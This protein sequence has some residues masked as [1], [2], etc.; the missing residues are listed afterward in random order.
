MNFFAYILRRAARHWQILLTLILGVLLSTALLASS[1]VLINTVVE[2]GLRRNLLAAPPLEGN[3]RLRAYSNR[4]QAE[5]EALSQQVTQIINQRLG[6]HVSAIVPSVQTRAFFPWLRAQPLPEQ[7][8]SLLFYGQGETDIA[9]R[10][11]F[12]AG[13]WPQEPLVDER[14]LAVVIGADMATAYQLEVGDRLPLSEKQSAAQPDL[15]LAVVGIATPLEPLDRYWFGEFNPL[16]ERVDERQQ[17]VYTAVMPA[18]DFFRSNTTFFVNAPLDMYWQVLLAPETIG[19]QDIPALRSQLGR[20][21][22]DL[23]LLSP[24]ITVNTGL[25]KMLANFAAQAATVRAPL[26]FLTAEVVLLILYYV[27]MVSA[28]A[29]RQ[30]ERE[31]AVLQS[32]GASGGQIFRIQ[33]GE[34]LIISLVAL[35]A[36]PGLGLA[37]VRGLVVAGPLADV[38][39]PGWAL[40][41]PQVA[42]LTAVV[43][44]LAALAGLLLP[45]RAAIKRSIIAYQ[46]A[47][48]R[49]T[50]VP[51]WQRYYL[52]V[53][54]LALGLALLLR[55][56]FYGSIVGGSGARPQVD[57]LLLLSPIALLVG[58]GAILLRI[59]PLVLRLLAAVAS[60]GRGLPAALALWQTARNPSHVARLVLLLTLA[61]SLGILSTGINATLDASEAERARYETGGEVRLASRRFVPL[62]QVGTL[63]G[64]ADLTSVWR[65]QGS[66][67]IGRDYLRF[68][69]LAIEPYSFAHVTRY[70]EDFSE[71]GMGELLGDLVVDD[72]RSQPLILLPGKP[73]EFGLWLW[74]A[75]TQ[76]QSGPVLSGDS[77]LDRVGLEVKLQTVQ[78]ELLNLELT[79]TETGGY[80]A[81]GWRYFRADLPPL[82]DFNYPVGVHSIWL[83][84]LARTA[85][86]NRNTATS[87][88]LAV[89]TLTVVDKVTG[90]TA[91][92]NDM[93][94]LTEIWYL[95]MLGAEKG[96]NTISFNYAIFHTGKASQWLFLN[97]NALQQ[98]ALKLV[99]PTLKPAP[100]P[101]LAHAKFLQSVQGQVGDELT[102]V[103][104][105]QPM[106][107]RVVGVVNYFPTMYAEQTAGYLIMNRDALLNALNDSASQSVNVN[108]VL[109]MVEGDVDQ[110][111]VASTALTA[112]TSINQAWSV[113]AIRKAIKADPMALGLRSVTF[114]GYVLTTMLS[115]VGFG[116]YFY[117][118]ARQRENMYGVLRSIGMSPRQLYGALALEQVVLI[119]AGL[120]I[121][122]VLGVALNQITLPGLPI[123]FSDRSPTPPF[124]ALND[125]LAVARIYL[126]LAFAFLITLGLAT[127]LLWRTRLHRVLRVGEE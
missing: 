113:D 122:T 11:R 47:A 77:D 32:R 94:T 70:R 37:L 91:V 115:L 110:V 46:Q 81:D 69:I 44:V 66:T 30:V 93:E 98:V 16:R 109:L 89:D 13:G 75:E 9:T 43:G 108:E 45:V 1:P 12:E 25:D 65:A 52:D 33:L 27:T 5:Y 36:G 116:T 15:W 125:W 55:L 59:F 20:L 35:L 78:G 26:Y 22:D 92:V 53:F 95:D 3:L 79:P 99:A 71:R 10:V 85:N 119:F 62:S 107:I 58:S 118:S 17:V 83:R 48:V 72:V 61:M 64:V 120:V 34:A 24:T 82:A 124:R 6:E 103:L 39:E 96:A 87:M 101:A 123:T 121:G 102:I 19:S 8:V 4:S 42:W 73:A 90:E 28:L 63:E 100:V 50:A 111:D 23:S 18:A 7:H 112:I 84:N 86:F 67:R 106:S 49:D 104:N 51:F 60:R 14:T 40:T 117:M 97:L 74:S 68:D 56:H 38:A 41:L 105:S 126:T 127:L 31:F 76:S 54:A 2:F 21:R 57:W 29:V 114:F 80:P 88:Q